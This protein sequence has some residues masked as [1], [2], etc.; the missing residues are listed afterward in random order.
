MFYIYYNKIKTLSETF[1]KKN[2]DLCTKNRCHLKKTNKTQKTALRW[3]FV[4]GFFGFYWAGF[5]LPT[6]NLI[7]VWFYVIAFHKENEK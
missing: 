5:L 2:S 3:V 6:L 1:F 7:P 4:G